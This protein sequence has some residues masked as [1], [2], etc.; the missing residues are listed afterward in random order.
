MSGN[1]GLAEPMAAVAVTDS[2]PAAAKSELV[3]RRGRQDWPIVMVG[4][5]ASGIQSIISHR[6]SI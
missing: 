1:G 6:K 2:D 4:T 3:G 5:V